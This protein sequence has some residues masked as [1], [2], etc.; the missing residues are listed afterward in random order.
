MGVGI[1]EKGIR[2]EIDGRG[3]RNVAR[4]GLPL[5][6]DPHRGEIHDVFIQPIGIPFAESL[7]SSP[8]T[9]AGE[10]QPGATDPGAAAEQVRQGDGGVRQC[11]SSH[12]SQ[13]IAGRCV[14]TPF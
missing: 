5:A 4:G 14:N 12:S 11:R 13:L 7:G 9:A 3:A 8:N 1:G 2:D 10:V 6:F